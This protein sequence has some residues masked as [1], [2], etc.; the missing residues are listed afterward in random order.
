MK[1]FITK[2]AWMLYIPSVLLSQLAVSVVPDCLPILIVLAKTLLP[3][4]TMFLIFS[5]LQ[6]N[7]TQ[8]AL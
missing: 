8:Y 3:E 7:G 4:E 5:E 1:A 6:N 2:N